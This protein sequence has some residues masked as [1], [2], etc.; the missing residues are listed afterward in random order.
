MKKSKNIH[1][2]IPI[3]SIVVV[4]AALLVGGCIS[5][6]PKSEL[7]TS[8]GTLVITDVEFVDSFP[9]GCTIEPG[10]EYPTDYHKILVVWI[11][12][13]DGG[14]LEEV[15][16]KLMEEVSPFINGKSDGLY[17]TASDG[18]QTNLLRVHE[19]YEKSNS[20]FAL[21]FAPPASANDF[22]LFW[23]GNPAID[24]GTGIAPARTTTE[25]SPAVSNGEAEVIIHNDISLTILGWSQSSGDDEIKPEEGKKFVLVDVVL[26]NR[27]SKILNFIDRENMKLRDS[28][29]QQYDADTRYY[30]TLSDPSPFGDGFIP[31]ERMR[32]HVLFQV[33]IASSGYTFVFNTTRVYFFET[34]EDIS[35]VLSAQ[36]VSIKPSAEF[37]TPFPGT[38]KIGDVITDGDLALSVLGWEY[39]IDEQDTTLPKDMK[40]V[41]VDLEAVNHGKQTLVLSNWKIGLKDI[42]GEEYDYSLPPSRYSYPYSFYT[43]EMSA[44]YIAPGELVRGKK[45]FK[46]PKEVNNLFLHIDSLNFTAPYD[47]IRAKVLIEL[48]EKPVTI[49]LPSQLSGEQSVQT[50]AI[51]ESVQMGNLL[52][53]VTDV[54]FPE[55]IAYEKP[56][57]GG[58]WVVINI[59]EQNTAAKAND[60]PFMQYYLKD[61]DG[62]YY[63]SIISNNQGF[64]KGGVLTP[65][66][67]LGY[68]VPKETRE[69]SFI[70]ETDDLETHKPYKTFISLCGSS[71][72]KC[73]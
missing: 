48:G 7:K 5:S 73:E 8:A 6:Q 56:V 72:S 9:P 34:G 61:E 16:D 23:P 41:V 20:R 60:D 33:P 32:G 62:R 68:M 53:K 54:A 35:S 47:P 13:K 12:R 29:G 67:T 17:V 26:T 2:Y 39:V 38:R 1:S 63:E 50:H 18:S 11:E 64:W 42:T 30:Y 49:P 36:P 15:S 51:G 4:V 31:G 69:L 22:R 71:I 57:E 52:L 70:F 21:V 55:E 40:Y 66:V 25:A 27:G 24:L 45:S 43:L 44:H 58:K 37:L 65:G 28:S 46:V 59:T 3:L 19:Q 14:N 10:C